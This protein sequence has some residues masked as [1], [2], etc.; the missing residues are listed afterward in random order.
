MPVFE[1]RKVNE[2][3]KYRRITSKC[4]YSKQKNILRQKKGLFVPE[5][6]IQ[7]TMQRCQ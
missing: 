3:Q 6:V 5:K 4:N 1:K 7:V 2:L